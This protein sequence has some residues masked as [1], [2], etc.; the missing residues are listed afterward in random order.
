MGG[1]GYSL[2]LVTSG[3]VARITMDER[4]PPMLAIDLTLYNPSGTAVAS[5]LQ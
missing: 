5:T 4:K 3:Q 2:V 1:Y